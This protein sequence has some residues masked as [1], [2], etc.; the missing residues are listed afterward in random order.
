MTCEVQCCAVE[1]WSFELSQAAEI[2]LWRSFPSLWLPGRLDQ[3][4]LHC[5]WYINGGMYFTCFSSIDYCFSKSFFGFR[6]YYR[7]IG[8]PSCFF[9]VFFIIIF[10][11]LIWW[12]FSFM[13]IESAFMYVNNILSKIV[14]AQNRTSFVASGN[15]L[16]V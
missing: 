3:I 15:M 1:L 11:V 10:F 5:V 13:N 6:L 16:L 9:V 2:W 7:E 14:S 12:H 8:P 4:L